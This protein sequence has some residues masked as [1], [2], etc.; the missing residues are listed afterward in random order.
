MT[1]LLISLFLLDI[2]FIHIS[3]VIPFP[4]SCLPT[5]RNS[6]SHHPSPCFYKG[7]L[8]PP[9]LSSAPSHSP[10][11]GHQAFTRQRA[12]SPIDARQGHPL[13]AR[14][15]GSL[16]VYC[17]VCG[18]LPRSSRGICLVDI[19]VLPMGLQTPSSPS[20]LYLT[21]PLG[22]PCSVQWL[23][24]SISLCI[25]QVLAEP[26]ERQLHQA[27]VTMHF[28]TSTIVSVFDDCV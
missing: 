17:L 26:L 8:P 2:F 18:L 9:T 24:M 16:H 13:P 15:M 4:S 27:P 21:P 14:A 12:P 3:N 7:A 22:T 1:A 28:L 5:P 11:L 25:C 10:A 6:L 23:S 20:V 19:V